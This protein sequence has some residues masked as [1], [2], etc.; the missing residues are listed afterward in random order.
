MAQTGEFEK[1][2]RMSGLLRSGGCFIYF[3][4]R[5]IQAIRILQEFVLPSVWDPLKLHKLAVRRDRMLGERGRPGELKISYCII[6]F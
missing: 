1:Q 6:F 3:F 5:G 4:I 2:N